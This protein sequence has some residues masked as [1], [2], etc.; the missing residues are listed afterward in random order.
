MSK[1]FI[2]FLFI[3]DDKDEFTEDQIYDMIKEN[4]LE[5]ADNAPFRIVGMAVNEQKK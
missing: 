1:K 2:A 3:S 4:M 5:Y